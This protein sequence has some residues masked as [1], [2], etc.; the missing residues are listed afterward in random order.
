MSDYIIHNIGL[1]VSPQLDFGQQEEAD[2]PVA[3]FPNYYLGKIIGEK[4]NELSLN[5]TRRGSGEEHVPNCVLRN[6]EGI[7]LIR[8]HNKEDLVIVNLPE[9]AVEDCDVEPKSSYPFAYV[10]VDYRD[11]KCQLAIEKTSAWDSKTTTI[12]NCFESFFNEKLSDSLGITT[13]LKEKTE[14]TEFEQ[15]IDE[16]TI[17]H[18]DVIESFTFQYV[19]IKRN[20]TARI[21]DSLTEQM[22]MMS[23]VLEM[24]DAISGTTTMKMG[25]AV[26][27]TKLKQLSTVVTMCSDNAF[28]L[29]VK[30][31]DYG[32]YTCNESIIAKYPMNDAVI[33]LYK[34]FV[35]PDVHTVDFDL[36]L[37][38]D[39]VFTRINGKN[40][41]KQIPTKPTR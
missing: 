9:D 35:T 25:S 3:K 27:T 22:K 37:W 41:G 29:I 1:T 7:A 11:G 26:D 10:V 19:N 39:D 24:Y 6:E 13:N 18:G 14:S 20:P 33:S 5:R 30:F 17:D 4:G 34:D 8:I 31:K 40:D 23:S 15:F 36:R 16:R 28:D 12:R 32:D 2:K 21:P 38:L